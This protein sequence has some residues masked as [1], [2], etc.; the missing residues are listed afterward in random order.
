MCLVKKPKPVAVNREDNRDLPILR[1]PFLD[2]IDPILRARQT[3]LR[4]L[5]IDRA[6]PAAAPGPAPAASPL[7]ITRPTA[8]VAD[9]KRAKLAA[10]GSLPG[11]IGVVVRGLVAKHSG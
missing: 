11:P 5:R 7:A 1:N 8:P 2:G 4:S 9:N 10:A 3:G 6:A